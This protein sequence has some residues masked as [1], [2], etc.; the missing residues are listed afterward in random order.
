MKRHKYQPNKQQ[1]FLSAHPVKA[2][3]ALSVEMN[4]RKS[5][6]AEENPPGSVILRQDARMESRRDVPSIIHPTR[7]KQGFAVPR[8]PP[9]KRKHTSSKGSSTE[10]GPGRHQSRQIPSATRQPVVVP[11]R[12]TAESDVGQK[13]RCGPAIIPLLIATTVWTRKV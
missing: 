12:S 6:R 10:G 3:A 8:R 11:P 7:D 5:R 9:P 2:P 1:R 4:E 13:E